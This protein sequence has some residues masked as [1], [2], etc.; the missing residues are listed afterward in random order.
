MGK[1]WYIAECFSDKFGHMF[2][3]VR[4]G[5]GKVF[6]RLRLSSRPVWTKPGTK[7]DE[8][9]Q[10]QALP[11]LSRYD[12]AYPGI[13]RPKSGI[14]MISSLKHSRSPVIHV[15]KKIK[16]KRMKVYQTIKGPYARRRETKSF[17]WS[18][19][20]NRTFPHVKIPNC[21]MPD[22]VQETHGYTRFCPLPF[23][24]QPKSIGC[25]FN[26]GNMLR[27]QWRSPIYRSIIAVSSLTLERF[28]L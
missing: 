1:N 23:S 7:W 8:N 19:Q 3:P 2:F 20:C 25:F 4:E 14:L 24:K 26:S 13:L 18:N 22:F 11:K 10:N 15:L 16:I 5:S 21:T 27:T 12:R 9:G 28:S 6:T 17:R